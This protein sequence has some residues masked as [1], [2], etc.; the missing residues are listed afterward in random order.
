MKGQ[1]ADTSVINAIPLEVVRRQSTDTLAINDQQVVKA[2]QFINQNTKE[3]LQVSDVINHVGCSRRSLDEKFQNHL[4]YTVFAEIRRVRIENIAM[5]LLETDMS[6][7]QIALELGY[8]DSDHIARFFRQEKKMTP[9]AY[10][11]HFA[12]KKLAQ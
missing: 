9:Q 10:K 12:S 5:M 1:P 11:K 6:I 4:N 3:L 8:N 2:L 7:S